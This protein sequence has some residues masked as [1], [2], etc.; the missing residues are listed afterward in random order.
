MMPNPYHVFGN[1]A[2]QM[3]GRSRLA[4]RVLDRL[5][6]QHISVVGPRYFGKTV[7]LHGIANSPVVAQHFR[8]VVYWDLRH[9]T[10]TNDAEFFVGLADAARNQVHSCGNDAAEYFANAEDKTAHSIIGFFDYL[11][12]QNKRVLLVMDGMDQPLGSENLSPSVWDNLCALTERNSISML[13]ASRKR[14][15]QLCINP[16]SRT[17]DFWQRFVDP[18]VEMKTLTREELQEFIGPLVQH[19]GPLAAGADTEIWNW[20]GG[21]PLLAAALCEYLVHNTKPGG[22]APADVGIAA[23][24]ILTEKGDVVE[25]LWQEFDTEVQTA[26]VELVKQI[27]V[28]RSDFSAIGGKLIVLGLVL[29]C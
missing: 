20:T 10:P 15:R 18:V 3:L 26:F 14:L 16:N 12:D 4:E 6:T 9:L 13:T 25:A 19:V 17:S 27:E 11:K 28:N 5:R 24:H 8:D 21:L 7:L 1:P 23:H 2:P 22:L 29:L